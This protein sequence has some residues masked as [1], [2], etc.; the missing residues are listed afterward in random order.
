LASEL[1]R[2]TDMLLHS[3]TLSSYSGQHPTVDEHGFNDILF[4]AQ[5]TRFSIS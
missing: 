1:N 4:L 3:L 2:L 5:W